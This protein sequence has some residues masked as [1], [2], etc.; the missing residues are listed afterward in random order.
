[1]TVAPLLA[2]ASDPD[3][4]RQVVEG[5]CLPHESAT[6][7]PAPCRLVDLAAR[8][9][10][11]KDLQGRTQYLVIPTDTISGIESPAVLA[12]GA[13]DYWED[14]WEAR[15]F[16]DESAGQPVPRDSVGL[17]INSVKGRTQ[18]Q[19]HI[20]V[21]CVSPDVAKTLQD[22]VIPRGGGWTTVTLAGHPY[23]AR[24]LSEADLR[25]RDLFRLIA[26]GDPAARANM[27]L[28]TIVVVGASFVDSPPGFILLNDHA[29]PEAG[30]YAAGEELQDHACKVLTPAP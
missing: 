27:G 24:R 9:A 21:D 7:N 4:L 26:D 16:L 22:A 11:L 10:V 23:R 1:V 14:A 15:R 2:E 25:R 18:N 5:L 12:K 17:A 19:L 8:Y 13:P 6:G 20:H 28:E 29:N 3:A 30:D